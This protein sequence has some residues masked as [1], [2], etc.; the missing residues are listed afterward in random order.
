MIIAWRECVFN[1][2]TMKSLNGHNQGVWEYKD[3]S[4]LLTGNLFDNTGTIYTL[5]T[6]FRHGRDVDGADLD[7][8]CLDTDTSSNT[9]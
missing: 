7:R 5:S 8:D 2:M 4:V 6:L 1:C 9:R 3:N